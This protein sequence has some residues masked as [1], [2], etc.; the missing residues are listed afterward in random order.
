MERPHS[1]N[2]MLEAAWQF[3]DQPLPRNLVGTLPCPLPEHY[4]L[5]FDEQKIETE[6]M[7]QRFFRAI[8]NPDAATRDR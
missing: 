3:R 8:M 1:K 5:G 4:V 6:G 7:P 2:Y